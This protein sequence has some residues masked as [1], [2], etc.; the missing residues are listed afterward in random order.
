MKKAGLILIIF[1][2]IWAL[3]LH[4]AEESQA[5][6][7]FRRSY[8]QGIDFY[9]KG[10][11][12]KAINNFLQ[13]LNTENKH[14]EQWSAYNLGNAN[15]R[16]GQALEKE[17]PAQALS[18]YKQAQGFY[19]RAMDIN[20]KDL[21]AKYNYELTELKIKELSKQQQQQQQ[22]QQQEN[23][24]QDKNKEDMPQQ[25]SDQSASQDQEQPRDSSQS[26]GEHRQMSKQEA[27]MLLKNFEQSQQTAE[28]MVLKDDQQQQSRENEKDW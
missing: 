14:G 16:S 10:D 3:P 12:N 2:M 6:T 20:R 24:P 19:L 8:N 4:A 26:N 23:Q 9:N 21:D 15:F 17:N 5:K 18:A 27:E 13:A 7:D 11:Y 1:L 22:Q 25:S 28:P